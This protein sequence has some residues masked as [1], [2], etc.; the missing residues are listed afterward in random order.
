M[1][2]IIGLVCLFAL[3]IPIGAPPVNEK[4]Q[5]PP[6][7][8]DDADDQAADDVVGRNDFLTLI[9]ISYL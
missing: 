1:K 5:K 8:P 4:I 2:L 7:K 3:T 9:L 6:P